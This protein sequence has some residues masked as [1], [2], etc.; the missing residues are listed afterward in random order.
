MNLLK[1]LK[2]LGLLILSLRHRFPEDHRIIII[3]MPRLIHE[4]LIL[5]QR[6]IGI[7]RR[8]D[9]RIHRADPFQLSFGR[10]FHEFHKQFL[11]CSLR[12]RLT[13][14]IDIAQI[15]RIVTRHNCKH[16][17][18]LLHLDF[19]C[20]RNKFELLIGTI[21]HEYLFDIIDH[22]M[23]IRMSAGIERLLEKGLDQRHG[24]INTLHL[25][26]LALFQLQRIINHHIRKF[27]NP[28]IHQIFLSM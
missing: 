1:A 14:R 13:I 20:V 11:T 26:P 4:I 5:R 27:L 24:G 17:I 19:L 28:G 6:H 7:L 18:E 15:L 10:P 23:I 16:G 2:I 3:Q 9:C 25:H 21:F 12:Q 8:R 22:G